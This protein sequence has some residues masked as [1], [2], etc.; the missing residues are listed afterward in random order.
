MRSVIPPAEP[1]PT[2]TDVL[3]RIARTLG[4]EARL[5]LC[6]RRPLAPGAISRHPGQL[7][8][9]WLTAVLCWD[10]PGARVIAVQPRDAPSSGTT[11]RL[12]LTLTY[13]EAG[14]DSRLPRHVFVKC[15]SSLAQRLMLGFGGLIGS[16]PGFY[17][18]IRPRLDI[19][20]PAGYFGSV[21]PRSWRSV[22]VMEDVVVTKGA[23]FWQPDDAA[24]SRRRIESLLGQVAG[25]HGTLWESPA[26][27]E[28]DWLR[29]PAEQGQ[30]IDSLIALADS[31][32]AGAE[33][34]ADVI[35]AALRGRQP[36]LFEGMRRSME[37]M[38]RRPHT[39][40][41]GDLHVANT[42]STAT[43]SPGVCDWQVGLK[44]CWAY[45]V[46]YLLSTALEVED[47]RA[48]E[49]ELL[50]LYVERLR[51]AGGGR[52]AMADAWLAYRQAT[53]YPYFAWIYTLGRSRFQ[54]RFQPDS[55]SLMMIARIS[56]AIDDL[57]SLRAVGL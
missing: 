52:V 17:E 37:L 24:I 9:E 29:T 8:P 22:V 1:V 57:E 40:L 48:W 56:A 12:A 41:H 5:R 44:G 36:D 39:Y 32:R 42:Y 2:K 21:D 7:T 6:D 30:L 50:E 53:L 55:V 47:R 38:G 19:R 31:T 18:L 35:P 15:T 27:G 43:G 26:L 25:W 4:A 14:A 45:D 16:E 54:P 49:G 51:A 13:N 3:R 46:S 23:R 34:A 33:R 20:A 28:W 10:N 11:T